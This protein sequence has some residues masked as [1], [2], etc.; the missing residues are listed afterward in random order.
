MKHDQS[1]TKILSFLASPEATPDLSFS[2]FVRGAAPATLFHRKGILQSVQPLIRQLFI[3][4]MR[5]ARSPLRSG[6]TAV[7]EWTEVSVQVE[8]PAPTWR[9]YKKNSGFVVREAQILIPDP[10]YIRPACLGKWL[11]LQAP[12]FP[13]L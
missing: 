4:P 10:P 2:W 1:R 5:C 6:N 7:R 8:L 3:D 11:D 12:H 9:I 13:H